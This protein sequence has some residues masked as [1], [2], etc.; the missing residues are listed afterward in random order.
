MEDLFTL[1]ATWHR[2]GFQ[3]TSPM[4]VL[5]SVRLWLLEHMKCEVIKE[6][7]E[8]WFCKRPG[9][10]YG[11][12]FSWKQRTPFEGIL[13]VYSRY[14][15]SIGIG[16]G[17]SVCVCVCVCIPT[18]IP[19]VVFCAIVGHVQVITWYKVNKQVVSFRKRSCFNYVCFWFFGRVD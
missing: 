15:T 13:V 9:S 17:K 14:F 18:G 6:F 4:F 12:L 16:P 2:A 5:T 3:I 1:L 8:I 7:P 10:F 11:T 19:L